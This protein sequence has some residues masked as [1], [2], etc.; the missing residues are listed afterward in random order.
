MGYNA[1]GRI[2][3]RWRAGRR[4]GATYRRLRATSHL[5]YR[6]PPSFVCRS[7]AMHQYFNDSAKFDKRCMNDLR[8]KTPT[9]LSYRA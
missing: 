4:V 8:L 2:D 1:A 6:G 3:Q 7:Y 5:I 9:C